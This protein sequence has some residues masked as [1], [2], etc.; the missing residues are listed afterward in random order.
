MESP[1][2]D[3]VATT[4]TTTTP[5]RD[6]PVRKRPISRHTLPE[7]S[8]IFAMPPPRPQYYTDQGLR[9]V[10]PYW[11]A[12]NAYAKQRWQNRSL[13]DVLA[14]PPRR[15]DTLFVLTSRH[16]TPTDRHDLGDWIRDRSHEYY[17]WSIETGAIIVNNERT[18]PE[19][20]LKN[21]DMISNVVH[22]SVLVLTPLLSGLRSL[23]SPGGL[24]P[25]RHE[26]PVVAGP[27][28]I[29]YDGRLPGNDGETLVVEKPGSMPVHST[30]RYHFNTLL[31]I[32]KH[33]YD[34]PLVHSKSMFSMNV[35]SS[36][37]EFVALT[38]PP[39]PCAASNR[40]DRLTSGVMIC[41]L[42]VD[43]SKK[44]G[45]W[46]GGQRRDGGTVHKE[47]VARCVGKFPEE[48]VSCEE[49][50]MTID[51]Q[52]GI[53]VVHSEGRS[54]KTI[55]T[56]LSY[57]AKSN[58]SAVHCRP[59]TGRSHQIRVHLQF[60]GFPIANDPI[61][62]NSA[63]WGTSG[64]KG[65]VFPSST[66]E[67]EQYVKGGSFGGE[68]R[69]GGDEDRQER[70]DRGD[71]LMRSAQ[72]K[73]LDLSSIA[74]A[75]SLDDHSGPH[76]NATGDERSKEEGK[77]KTENEPNKAQKDLDDEGVDLDR[78]PH[79][80]SITPAARTA[81][82]ALRDVKDEADGWARS[83]D[84]RGLE[85]ARLGAEG[86]GCVGNAERAMLDVAQS[87]AEAEEGQFTDDVEATS[88]WV[89]K[90]PTFC[91]DCFTP[92]VP[93]PRP[94]QLFIW[95]HALRCECAL[96]KLCGVR[97]EQTDPLTDWTG[98]DRTTEWDYSS[99]LPYWAEADYDVPLSSILA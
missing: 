98:A 50:L 26:P 6:R 54:A 8:G 31:S 78:K 59:I 60:L 64:G 24:P 19:Y 73:S 99:P 49:P 67:R 90:D 15:R 71:K 34:L 81:I 84:L 61:Y 27:I 36:I 13:I 21:G 43:A 33:D 44:L 77:A 96:P 10:R 74:A 14:L 95:L 48:E 38:C 53:N 91:R 83:R 75:M 51:R 93:D 2:Q 85:L 37:V 92:L 30:G 97:S 86:H 72:Q 79:D 88:K 89:E 16:N 66:E 25:H 70:R 28:R 20:I 68:E 45:A 39:L 58:T 56:R 41:A 29:I 3:D 62:Q 23:I 1:T 11:Y 46:F 47:Y 63:A 18:T 35:S 22:R 69:G 40:L 5:V 12:F 94:E 9:K 4:T 17:I 82:L 57:D 42:T 7:P 76:T 32:L 65:G 55:F 87:K 52:I 80:P